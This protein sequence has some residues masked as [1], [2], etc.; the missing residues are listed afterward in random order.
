MSIFYYRD[1]RPTPNIYRPEV[2]NQMGQ[3]VSSAFAGYSTAPF[4]NP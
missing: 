3:A 2:L 1:G 4:K